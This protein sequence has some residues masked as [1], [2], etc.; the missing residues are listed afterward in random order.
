MAPGLTDRTQIQ[1]F[2]K[3]KRKYMDFLL[4]FK[5]KASLASLKL[6][7]EPGGLPAGPDYAAVD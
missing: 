1:I 2:Y 4:Y 6:S 3:F 7:T 5:C